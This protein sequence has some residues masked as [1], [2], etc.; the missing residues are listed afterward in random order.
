M[1]QLMQ[2][3]PTDKLDYDFDFAEWLTPGD[4]I[5]S[6]AA[7]ISGGTAAIDMTQV[8]D[9]RVKVWVSGGAD[10]ETNDVQVTITTSGGR[11]KTSCFRLRIKDC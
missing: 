10:A 8:T 4:V 9:D 7:E 3:T 11:E 6:A 5:V 2:K 1:T